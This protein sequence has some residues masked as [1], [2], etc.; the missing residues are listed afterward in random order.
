MNNFLNHV[1]RRKRGERGFASLI[2]LV[3]LAIM[4][5][6]VINNGVVLNQLRQNLRLIEQRQQKKFK[7]PADAHLR[8]SK[9]EELRRGSSVAIHHPRWGGSSP[10]FRARFSGEGEEK[11][12]SE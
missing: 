11:D 8:S 7:K 3:L 12:S 10:P 6:Y 1:S 9:G 4:V 2:V 5:M